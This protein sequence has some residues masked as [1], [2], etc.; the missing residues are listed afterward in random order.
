MLT[1]NVQ[2][3]KVLSVQTTEPN[4]KA[5]ALEAFKIAAVKEFMS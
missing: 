5:I 4:M 1:L 3:D 2:G